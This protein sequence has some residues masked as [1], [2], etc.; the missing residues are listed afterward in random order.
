MRFSTPSRTRDLLPM[1]EAAQAQLP[2]ETAALALIELQT[3][4]DDDV[5]GDLF[6]KGRSLPLP[7]D[8]SDFIFP[9]SVIICH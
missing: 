1:Q 3:S 5:T 2:N 4:T 9:L 6:K 7:T 8:K